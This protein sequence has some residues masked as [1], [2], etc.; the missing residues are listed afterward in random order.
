MIILNDASYV[1]QSWHATLLTI[2]T[3]SVA[4]VFNSFFVRKLPLIEGLVLVLLIFGFFGVLI[5]LWSVLRRSTQQD[6]IS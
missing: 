4:V 3:V 5:P 6:V 2:A 1:P